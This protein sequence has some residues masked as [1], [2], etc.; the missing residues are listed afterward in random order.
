MGEYAKTLVRNIK[1]FRDYAKE[2]TAL[3]NEYMVMPIKRAAISKE[4]YEDGV[5]IGYVYTLLRFTPATDGG[6]LRG[7]LV[8]VLDVFGVQCISAILDQTEL[9]S[10]ER[11]EIDRSVVL[12]MAKKADISKVRGKVRQVRAA[13]ADEGRFRIAHERASKFAA[14]V[15]RDLLEGALMGESTDSLRHRLRN[16]D[17]IWEKF[18]N[19]G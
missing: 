19:A 3:V 7:Q 11:G 10:P 13:F 5:M 16:I 15:A 12:E 18:R 1:N 4:V 8:G 2:L 6:K 9:L 17:S 14:F